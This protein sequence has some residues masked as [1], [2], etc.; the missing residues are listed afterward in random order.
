MTNNNIAGEV[1]V[2]DDL[3][4][5]LQQQQTV[6]HEEKTIR[7]PR[8]A[9]ETGRDDRKEVPNGSADTADRGHSVQMGA[10]R[11]LGAGACYRRATAS[12]SEGKQHG[13]F[14]FGR[15]RGDLQSQFHQFLQYKRQSEV[16]RHEIYAI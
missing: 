3:I 7:P 12:T 4:H 2:G 15:G 11:P 6:R 10:K 14:R 5:G 8:N 16:Q 13:P 9:M 1:Q